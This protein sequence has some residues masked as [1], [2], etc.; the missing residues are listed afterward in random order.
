MSKRILI[1]VALVVLAA[2]AVGAVLGWQNAGE[3]D[4]SHKYEGV[5]LNADVGEITRD[6]TYSEYLLQ[7]ANAALPEKTVQIDALSYEQPRTGSWL[8]RFFG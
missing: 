7:H 8:S 4:Y 5:D 3:N 6:D 1:I 2:L